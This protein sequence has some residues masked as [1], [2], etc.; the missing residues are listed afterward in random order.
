M[1]YINVFSMQNAS[2]GYNG[3][4][5]VIVPPDIN[6]DLMLVHGITPVSYDLK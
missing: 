5:T 3:S 1:S 4:W 6:G 2:S